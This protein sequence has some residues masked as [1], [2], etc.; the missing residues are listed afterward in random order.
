[1]SD[2]KEKDLKFD[3]E[4][5]PTF[6]ADEV[7]VVHNPLKFILD[8]KNIT[9]RIDIRNKDFQPLVLKHNAIVLDPWTVKSFAEALNEN[10][11]NYEAKF[12]KIK[13]PKPIEIM[14]KEAKIGTAKGKKEDMPSYLG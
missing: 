5:G 7:G 12:G 13:T 1:M 11:K 8:F 9:P 3:I 4:N 6:H 14:N 10:I 2:K